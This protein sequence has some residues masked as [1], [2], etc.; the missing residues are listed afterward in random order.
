MRTLTRVGLALIVSVTI[1]CSGCQKPSTPKPAVDD[2]VFRKPTAT[3]VFNLRSKCA[4]LGDK[5]P[6]ASLLN[7]NLDQHHVSHYDPQTNRCYIE[8]TVYTVDPSKHEDHHSR[9][10]W[11]GQTGELLV[12]IRSN[13]GVKTAYIKGGSNDYDIAQAMIDTAMAD[14]RKQ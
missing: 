6:N 8:V 13:K 5:I 3:E 7:P 10:L 2:P 9:N 11:D 14:D 1:V 4:E 12:S